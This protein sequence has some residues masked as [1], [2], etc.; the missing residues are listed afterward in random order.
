LSVLDN[1]LFSDI[2]TNRDIKA[3]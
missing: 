1:G 2:L 3:I